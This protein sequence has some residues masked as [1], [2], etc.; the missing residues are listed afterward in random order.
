M[1]F[2]PLLIFSSLSDE[3]R[4]KETASNSTVTIT[5]VKAARQGNK[6]T[7]RNVKIIL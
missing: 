7:F 5:D 1:K 2:S 3:V 4:A 6:I